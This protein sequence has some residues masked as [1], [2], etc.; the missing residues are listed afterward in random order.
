MTELLIVNPLRGLAATEDS[1]WRL[2]DNLSYK[3]QISNWWLTADMGG[4][5]SDPRRKHDDFFCGMMEVI[6]EFGSKYERPAI[7]K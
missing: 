2:Y 5:P 7:S 3:T 6:N 4:G 1:I